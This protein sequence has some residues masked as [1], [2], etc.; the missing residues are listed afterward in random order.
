MKK[1]TIGRE[2][3]QFSLR[4]PDGMR[5]QVKRAAERNRRSTNAELIFL[6]E[7]GIQAGCDEKPVGGAQEHGGAA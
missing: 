2:S 1:A 6:I 3:E 7:R 5:D 4:F